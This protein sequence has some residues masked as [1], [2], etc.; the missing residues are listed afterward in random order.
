[1]IGHKEWTNTKIDPRG[2][3]LP[4]MRARI[5]KR[6]GST[7]GGDGSTSGGGTQL[8]VSVAHIIAAAKADPP[9]AQGHTTHKTEVLCVE[10]VLVAEGLLAEQWADGSFGTK[11][12]SAY[13]A[14]Q[15]RCGYT[16]NDADG[17][18]GS[19]S[20]IALGKRHGFT[21]K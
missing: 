1:M 9:A 13:A 12:V 19:D 21:V 3:S 18:P 17:I 11:T 14:W 5:A 20:L 8:T 7:P 6:L 2:Y 4:D 10:R 15:K 16:G